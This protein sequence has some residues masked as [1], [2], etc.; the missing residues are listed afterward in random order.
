MFP[1]AGEV[2]QDEGSTEEGGQPPLQRPIQ[3]IRCTTHT[4]RDVNPILLA[5]LRACAGTERVT[6][7]LWLRPLQGS[8]NI[9]PLLLLL[10]QKKLKPNNESPKQASQMPKHEDMGKKAAYFIRSKIS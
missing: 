4:K 8:S 5:R 10:Q 7:K 6:L 3:H 9:P 2:E 1:F